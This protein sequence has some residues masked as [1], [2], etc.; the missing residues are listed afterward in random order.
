MSISDDMYQ[1]CFHII[2]KLHVAIIAKKQDLI[3]MTSVR[4]RLM[5]IKPIY[6][7]NIMLC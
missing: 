3:L 1:K 6:I 5:I 4:I 2:T 7:L